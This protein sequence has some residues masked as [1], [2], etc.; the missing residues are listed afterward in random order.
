MKQEKVLSVC[1][2]ILSNYSFSNTACLYIFRYND[3]W[4]HRLCSGLADITIKPQVK[5]N[6][7]SRYPC[8]RHE[9]M[10]GS[11]G[12]HPSILNLGAASR[13]A[14]TFM[15]QTLYCWGMIPRNRGLHGPQGLRGERHLPVQRTEKRFYCRPACS[16]V[17]KMTTLS[18]FSLNLRQYLKTDKK[19]GKYIKTDFRT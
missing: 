1:V 2:I 5:S 8:S 6:K 15:P 18:Q 11:G 16:L 9:G 14:V 17:S 13:W 19:S 10:W 4:K 7:T 12:R 3:K